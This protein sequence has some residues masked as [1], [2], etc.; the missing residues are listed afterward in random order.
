MLPGTDASWR[1]PALTGRKG[2]SAATVSSRLLQ[3]LPV[4]TVPS[5]T[6]AAS[7]TYADAGVDIS[8]G[9]RTK[10][11]IKYLAQ[12]TFTKQVLSEIGG[13][14]GLFPCWYRA[15]TASGPS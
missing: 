13:F 12:R 6:S 5:K 9:D 15:P 14:G 7:I 11:R 4:P 8:S 1:A 10:Q 3:R 2:P